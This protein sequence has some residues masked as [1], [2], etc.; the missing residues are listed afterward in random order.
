MFK[1]FSNQFENNPI[2]KRRTDEINFKFN[3]NIFSYTDSKFFINSNNNSFDFNI[4][5]ENNNKKDLNN[6]NLTHK[7]INS[8]KIDIHNKRRTFTEKTKTYPP[9]SLKNDKINNESWFEEIINKIE[10]KNIENLQ[11]IQNDFIKELNDIYSENFKRIEEVNKKYNNEIYIISED[12]DNIEEKEIYNQLLNE[13]NEC[14]E[15]I[16]SE[17]IIKKNCSLLK[18]NDR[19]IKLK[20]NIINEI[21]EEGKNIKDECI[22]IYNMKNSL[23]AKI[24]SSLNF[25]NKKKKN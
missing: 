12:N 23:R 8:S 7:K 18:Y 21:N 17:F 16:E 6:N 13:K 11:K 22:N 19:I 15:E 10:V 5:E 1:T 4:S 3:E 24:P 14:L 9:S 2:V 25:R 20:E